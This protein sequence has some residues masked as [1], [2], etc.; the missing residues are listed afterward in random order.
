M[1]DQEIIEDWLLSGINLSKLPTIA[2]SEEIY[3]FIIAT[4]DRIGDAYKVNSLWQLI[5]KK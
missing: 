2:Y 1:T 5:V 4:C 3:N